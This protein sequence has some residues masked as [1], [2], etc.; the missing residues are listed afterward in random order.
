VIA[1]DRFAEVAL[2]LGFITFHRVTADQFAELF[3]CFDRAEPTIEVHGRIDV[4]M[5]QN[6]AHGLVVAGMMLEID[7]RCRA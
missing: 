5:T 3:G 1:A 2:V 7:G 6:P 4:A